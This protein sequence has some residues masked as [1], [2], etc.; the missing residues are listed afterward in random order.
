[1]TLSIILRPMARQF[2]N[3]HNI[4]AKGYHSLRSKSDHID[5]FLNAFKALWKTCIQENYNLKA[6]N[7]QL[8][9]RYAQLLQENQRLNYAVNH[10]SLTGLYNRRYLNTY[11]E[12]V[13][14][15]STLAQH[16]LSLM[17]I[18]IDHFKHFNDTHGHQAGDQ[19]LQK[20]G[21]K[22]SAVVQKS[23]NC[24]A[25]YGGEEFVAVLPGHRQSEALEIA[26]T[27][28]T[29][30]HPLDITVSIGI[31]T[32]GQ[33]G[34]TPLDLLHCADQRLYAAKRNGRNRIEISSPPRA[35]T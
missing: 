4:P 23:D 21:N 26:K 35:D 14:T 11:M 8:K 9:E 5:G 1:M 19:L 15:T 2:R 20:V 16:K 27:I 32:Y 28:Q 3:N 6:E 29:A 12:Q 7:Q 17:V 22:L 33:D 34:K 13:C 25:R 31:A 18:D 24:I 30:I 10:D